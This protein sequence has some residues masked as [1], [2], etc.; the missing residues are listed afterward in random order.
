MNFPEP[1]A[2][3]A[4]PWRR[5]MRCRQEAER[6]SPRRS[7]RAELVTREVP[8]E[9]WARR[10]Q[11]RTPRPQKARLLKRSRP[12]SDRA[13]RR[14]IVRLVQRRQRDIAFEAAEHLAIDQN[15]P[16]IFGATVHDPMSHSDGTD[17]LCLAQPCA[18]RL[19]RGLRIIHFIRAVGLVD[20]GS[21]VGPSRT[22][23]TNDPCTPFP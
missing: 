4:A 13:D 17:I 5:P 18:G 11:H 22:P 16:I 14:K 12:L 9:L 3:E 21:P 19:E 2:T 15:W 8:P 6:R 10:M 1:A 20:Q 7:P 23:P